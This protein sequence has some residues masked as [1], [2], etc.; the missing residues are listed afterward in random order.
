MTVK[1]DLAKYCIILIDEMYAKEGLTFDKATGALIGLTD[2]GEV[3]NKIMEMEQL[4]C[5]L[6][7]PVAKT[8][9]TFMVKGLFT[10]IS[11]P[12][13]CYGCKRPRHVPVALG[14]SRLSY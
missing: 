10:D 8:V 1:G 3:T 4:K 5:G 6:S 11:F 9:L 14:Y 2:F 13:T 12:Y 7:R